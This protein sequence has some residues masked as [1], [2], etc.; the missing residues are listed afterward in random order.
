MTSVE[1]LVRY[2]EFVVINAEEPTLLPAALVEADKA[3]S[4]QWGDAREEIVGL[5]TAHRMAISP[6]GRNAKLASSAGK[7]TY[8]TQLKARRRAAMALLG[9]QG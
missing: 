8:G 4:D 2:P 5:E 1:F 7:T 6:F 9:R 3:V